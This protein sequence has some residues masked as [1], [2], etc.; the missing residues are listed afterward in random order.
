MSQPQ[1]RRA[2][3]QDCEV[4]IIGTGPY[5]LSLAAHLAATN[6]RFRIF[7]QPM[8]FWRQHIPK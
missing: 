2:K 4:A 8:A 3:P 6:I 5:G 1:A 7:G